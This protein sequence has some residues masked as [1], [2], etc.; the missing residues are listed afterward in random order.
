M[1]NNLVSDQDNIL[2]AL[3]KINECSS[4]I[5]AVVF[6]I[7]KQRQVIGTISDGDI[8]R[9][10][11]NGGT[12]HDNVC[13]VVHRNFIYVDDVQ[14]YDQIKKAKASGSPLV[15]ILDKD[16]KFVDLL[17]FKELR[18]LLPVDAIIMAGG[19]GRRL[20]PYTDKIPK[21]M[22][23]L[24][25]Q[26]IIAHNIDRLLKYGIKNL[27]I[28]V[29]HQKDIIKNYINEHD[30]YK[31]LNISFIEEDKPLGTIGSVKLA[32][33]LKNDTVLIMNSDIL[34]NIDY[35][36]LYESHKEH[37]ADMTVATFSVKVDIPYAVL[38][39]KKDRIT[40]FVEKPTYNYYSNAGIYLI[41][42]EVLDLI[43]YNQ[44]FDATDLMQKLIENDNVVNHFPIRGYWLDIGTPQNYSKTQKDIT[45]IK[46]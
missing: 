36:D 25:E 10:L 13:N 30:S 32:Q 46:F 24:A 37:K 16:K 18:S 3:K 35:A 1:K 12:L 38:A 11:I 45:F 9:Y 39:T 4:Q 44:R 15:P 29:N 42:K 14:D 40:S 20:K 27:N 17:N 2:E 26:P 8:R 33:N 31:N 7:N 41:N 21:P 23:E 6:V 22:L 34:T 43:P 5:S 28:S 19:E